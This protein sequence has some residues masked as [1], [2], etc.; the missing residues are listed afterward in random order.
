VGL[1]RAAAEHSSALRAIFLPIAPSH[2]FPQHS[3]PFRAPKMF[4]AEP[5]LAA[6]PQF[7]GTVDAP[8]RIRVVRAHWRLIPL[9]NVVKR[10]LY[11]SSRIALLPA[12]TYVIHKFFVGL[13]FP[14]IRP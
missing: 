8:F 5:L 4:G 13:S 12:N 2:F 9:A 7:F 11:F 6:N 3:A 10:R 1:V 14:D